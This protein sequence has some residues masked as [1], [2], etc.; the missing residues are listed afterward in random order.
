MSNIRRHRIASVAVG[1]AVLV[2]L[3]SVGAVADA[4]IGS[5]DIQDNSIAKRDIGPRA[6]GGSEVKLD[7][8][9]KKHLA[10]KLREQIN[11]MPLQ[12]E[13]GPAGPA[14]PAGPSGSGGG[15]TEDLLGALVAHDAYEGQFSGL[16]GA[17]FE[18]MFG[19]MLQLG[20]LVLPAGTHLL[21]ANVVAA[22]IVGGLQ[23]SGIVFVDQAGDPIGG[24]INI[25]PI[26]NAQQVVS[27][28]TSTTI[29]VLGML[30]P[31]FE[32]GDYDVWFKTSAIR[33]SSAFVE[34]LAA[35]SM[36]PDW[37]EPRLAQELE[38]SARQLQRQAR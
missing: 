31:P 13:P 35:D 28:P 38:R 2:S 29:R 7:S 22:D 30:Q 36:F 12:G 3:G 23:P 18:G 24:D 25:L 5:N 16:E 34:G 33:V 15:G 19:D 9:K 26:S 20:S 11:Q 10:P 14:G 17:E 21:T 37:E 8:I 32:E 6:V 1:A 27:V 4:L